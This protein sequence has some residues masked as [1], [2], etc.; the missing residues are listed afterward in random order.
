MMAKKITPLTILIFTDVSFIGIFFFLISMRTYEAA[1]LTAYAVGLWAFV[2]MIMSVIGFIRT[3]RTDLRLFYF[4]HGLFSI[5][6]F[7]VAE[8]GAF[9]SGVK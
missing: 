1:M 2:V 9:S 8:L 7:I 6:L 5:G 4:I 3:Q